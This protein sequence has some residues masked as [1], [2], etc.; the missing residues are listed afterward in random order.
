[1][2]HIYFLFAVTFL[3]VACQ[4]PTKT[5]FNNFSSLSDTLV[6][7]MK[8]QKGDGLFQIG[9]AT[10]KFKPVM[11]DFPYEIKF[12][13]N[14]DSLQ[15]TL[16][17][18]N[19]REKKNYYVDILTGTQHEKK[20]FIVDENNNKDLTDDAIRPLEVMEW[21]STKSL[22]KCLYTFSEGTLTIQDSSWLKIGTSNKNTLVSRS[23][24]VLGTFTLDSNSYT[25]M[26]ADPR[27]LSFTYD[28]HPELAIIKE[29]T[30]EKD[31]LAK[32]DIIH[33][34]EFVKL[35]TTYYKFH[36]ISSN[37]SQIT[38]IKEKDFDTKIGTQIGMLAPK[39][40]VVTTEKDTIKSSDLRDKTT[41]IANSCGCGG[42]TASTQAFYDMQVAFPKFN[43]LH[44][45]SNIQKT[46]SGLHI[47]FYNKFNKD[48]YEKYRGQYCLRVCYVIGKSGRILD[49]F[50]VT[51]WKN[52]L[53]ELVKE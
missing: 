27:N 51:D 41:V 35:H 12:P 49:T 21:N 13:T 4:Q 15:R 30:R 1:M 23:D 5:G 9:A 45:D 40:T 37:G 36:N 46:D 47:D 31:T 43:I 18:P 38:L 17:T 16:F 44:I 52:A 11:S 34:G 19:F 24:H 33:Y 3:L 2:K 28:I 53:L 25:I 26:V 20:V 10:P 14:I 48:F 6:V 32:R 42:D 8:K 39:F 29:Q 22:V 50:L 7:K